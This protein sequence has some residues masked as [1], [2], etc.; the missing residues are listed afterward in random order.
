MI[1]WLADYSQVIGFDVASYTEFK[2]ALSSMKNK[3]LD[4]TNE[5]LPRLIYANPQR[6]EQDLI[7]CLKLSQQLDLG[8]LW[9][10]LDGVEEL[11]KI[12]KICIVEG[13]PLSKI[14]LIL[15]VLVNDKQSS[16]PLGEKFGAASR[17][18]SILVDEGLNLGFQAENYLGV[19]FHCGSGCHDIETY[20]MALDKAKEAIDGIHNV[21]RKRTNSKHL[22]WLLDIGGG[23][24]GFDGAPDGLNGDGIYRFSSDISSQSK[25]RQHQ[26]G[27]VPNQQ[28]TTT[29]SIAQAIQPV[30]KEFKENDFHIIAEPGRYFV[31]GA[32]CL[33]SRIHKKRQTFLGGGRIFEY[34]IS[35]GVQGIFKDV[36]LCGESFTPSPLVIGKIAGVHNLQGSRVYGPSGGEQDVVC[37]YILLPELEIGDWLV[38]DRMGA[39]TLSI[40]SRTGRPVV[41][42][43][44]GGTCV[45]D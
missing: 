20:L 12:H 42:H 33:A 26:Q 18:I 9:L 34:T 27:Q 23:F 4:L 24:P 13:F 30:L 10:T 1:Q 14:G 11:Q 22:C 6:A 28:E 43:V 29:Y 39:Y 2:L 36:L 44:K 38:F 40:A 31:E 21:L 7:E 17:D 5:V 37:D 35:H 45:R 32:A 25:E 41:C 15:R 8:T 19:S 16:V 3:T